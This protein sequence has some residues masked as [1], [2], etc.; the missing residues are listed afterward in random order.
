VDPID[1]SGLWAMRNHE[2]I[3][4]NAVPGDYMGMPVN[5]EARARADAWSASNQSMPDRQC[6]MY[7]SFYTV[8]GPQGLRISPEIGPISGKVLAW[9]LSGAI[10]RTPRTIWMDGRAHPSA[11]ARH[12]AAGF[13]TGTWQGNTLMVHTTHLTASLL[14]RTGVPSSDEA[15]IDEYIMRHGDVLT[16]TMFL[17]DPVYLDGPYIRSRTWVL[18]PTIR[19]L[20]DPCEPV[21]EIPEP[22]GFVAHYLP[23]ANPY[24]KE[25]SQKLGIP[26]ETARGGIE[27]TYPEYQKRL[28][29]VHVLPLASK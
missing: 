22:R 13:S 9:H 11:Y 12:T 5:E 24:S 29:D 16:I 27:T 2:D 4:D 7:T 19:V 1:F 14:G 25:T 18:N 21:A 23:G 26:L 6:I 20:P 3:G 15:S 8:L 17:Y 10:D 28:K